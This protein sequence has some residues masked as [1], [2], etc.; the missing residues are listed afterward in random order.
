[1]NHLHLHGCCTT[2]CRQKTT[3]AQ[4]KV[5]VDF[6]S[7][8]H[9]ELNNETD[10]SDH[11]W[12]TRHI[13]ANSN[14]ESEGEY[15]VMALLGDIG[16]PLKSLKHERAYV[17]FIRCVAKHYDM[18]LVLAGNHCLYGA[19]SM[20][21]GQLRLSELCERIDDNVH[22]C[23]KRIASV[24]GGRVRLAC[25]GPLWSF[26]PPWCR[27]S[28]EMSVTDYDEIGDASSAERVTQWHLDELEWLR[29]ALRRDDDDNDNDS[30]CPSSPSKLVVLSHFAPSMAC[31]PEPHSAHT[32]AS[33]N[34][35]KR[36]ALDDV[37][38][39]RRREHIDAWL[40]G[41]THVPIR[42]MPSTNVQPSHRRACWLHS[43]PRGAPDEH[44]FSHLSSIYL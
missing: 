39:R 16:T 30:D 26:V 17:H 21:R 2:C 33:C 28:V 14:K 36:L 34:K 15:K 38:G 1:M 22:F 27:R 29:D 8:V 10:E 43:N 12:L 4:R 40:F 18:T 42:A 23:W 41:H 25:V 32:Y 19:K 6:I 11:S 35:L 24:D 20:E 7:D 44:L 5:R 9:L 3:V 37:A 31:V 13:E